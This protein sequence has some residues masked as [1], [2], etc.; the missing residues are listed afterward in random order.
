[1][2][3]IFMEI[4]MKIPLEPFFSSDN[5]LPHLSEKLGTPYAKITQI[6]TYFQSPIRNFWQSDEAL[7]VRQIQSKEVP[8]RVEFTY[9]GPKKGKTM[10]VREEIS[11]DVSSKE[12]LY[13][14]IA[15]KTMEEITRLRE[16]S[17]QVD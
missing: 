5:I 14:A 12:D 16:I 9:K 6:D 10:K 17:A 13:R 11:V 2:V 7:R 15:I 3:C 1:M 4:E 8:E